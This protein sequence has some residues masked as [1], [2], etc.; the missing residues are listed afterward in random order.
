MSNVTFDGETVFVP[1]VY[2]SQR[3]RSTLPGVLP[4]FQVPVMIGSAASGP[5][6]DVRAAS[7]AGEDIG[8]GP[9]VFCG[10]LGQVRNV[11]GFDSDM[12][13]AAKG[14]FAAG[15]G[16]IWCMNAADLTRAS[17]VA[18]S[19]GPVN[20]FTLYP[21]MWGAPGGWIRIAFG[22][23]TFTYTLPKR[24]TFLTATASATRAYVRDSSWLKV[25][26]SYTVIANDAPGI[27][28]TVASIGRE[29]DANGQ[30]KDFVE[31]TASLADDFAVAQYAAVVEY[32]PAV[33]SPA[34][35]ST[36]QKVIDYLNADGN[37][38]AVKHADFTN[39]ALISQA[40]KPILEAATW[41]SAAAGTSPAAASSDH[42]DLISLLAG[43]EIDKF[44][45]SQG[46]RP[47]A[48]LVL[49]S[50]TT[51]HASYRAFAA[52]RRAANPTEP[53]SI[54]AGTAWGDT[55]TS[56]SDSTS[57]VYRANALD[58]QDFQLVVGGIDRTAAYLSTA[59]QVFARRAFGG[60]GHNLTNDPLVINESVE[61]TWDERLS[62]Q[63]TTLLKGGCTTYR[64]NNQGQWVIAQGVSTL[65]N[66]L[67]VWNEDDATTYLVAQRDL[68]DYFDDRM[69]RTL[70]LTQVGADQVDPSSIA[71]A[72]RNRIDG[73]LARSGVVVSWRITSIKLN[74]GGAGYD[75]EH[76][77]ALPT[78]NDYINLRTTILVGA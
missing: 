29:I 25:G 77:V 34:T 8:L 53:I 49:S 62:G 35:L 51:I 32:F 74:A 28:R 68:A 23:S 78:T 4:T 11:F 64:L 26:K 66:N 38:V 57:G 39:A 47:Q 40:T 17:V 65:Q 12:A 1:G 14:I 58:S 31:F 36:A 15:G 18:T 60:I 76:S 41:A 5:P 54:V 20:Q 24:W 61:K 30:Y 22:S 44:V 33:A 71:D 42:D 3:V 2:V 6:F 10:D 13:I 16:G 43:S 50:D 73:D 19:T 59:P 37:F 69:A 55:S 63:I 72:M 27:S 75:V 21:K 48:F 46:A 56:A 52:T 45:E 67:T 7:P 9:W 70:D